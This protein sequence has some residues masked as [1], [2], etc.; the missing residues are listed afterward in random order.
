LSAS[1][2]DS[3]VTERWSAVVR[4]GYL[5]CGDV[6]IAEDLAQ[7]AFV[8]LHRHWRRVSAG[9]PPDA[10][11]RRIVVNL[12]ARRWR[13]RQPEQLVA[14]PPEAPLAADEYAV[15]DQRDEIWRALRTLPPRM[16]AVLVLRYY[17]GL[18]ERETALSLGCAVGTVKSQTSQGIRR[19]R[20]LLDTPTST[21][22]VHR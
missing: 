10:Y 22:G 13:R 2:F 18:T 6:M 20:A 3:Y 12:A 1:D 7:T 19:L 5:L 8:R 9:G 11:V 21:S 4:V 16:R 17:E 14:S 15:L